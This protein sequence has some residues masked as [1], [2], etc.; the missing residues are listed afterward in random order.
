MNTPT[1]PGVPYQTVATDLGA[2]DAALDWETAQDS[3]PGCG[4]T[5]FFGGAWCGECRAQR[6]GH[7]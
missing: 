4:D 5:D 2:E 6:M 7:R 1:V 3:C